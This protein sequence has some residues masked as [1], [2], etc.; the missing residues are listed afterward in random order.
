MY[1]FTP[2]PPSQIRPLVQAPAFSTRSQAQLGNAFVF[3]APLRVLS[4]SC[5]REA[6]ASLQVCS[7]AGAWEQEKK[8][9][10]ILFNPA[11]LTSQ[12]NILSFIISL[13]NIY[14]F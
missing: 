12:K 8:T 4:S 5:L 7:Q 10:K 2:Y 13:N 11:L 14:C 6:G 9:R 1:F 3:E